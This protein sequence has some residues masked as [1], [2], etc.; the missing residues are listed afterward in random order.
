MENKAGFMFSDEGECVKVQQGYCRSGI[1]KGFAAFFLNNDVEIGVYHKRMM[2][3]VKDFPDWA[4]MSAHE[5]Y[6]E[7]LNSLHHLG[8]L[9]DQGDYMRADLEREYRKELNE[10]FVHKFCAPKGTSEFLSVRVDVE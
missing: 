4:E 10:I 5:A 7:R 3:W 1:P 6:M 9:G 2:A 8:P